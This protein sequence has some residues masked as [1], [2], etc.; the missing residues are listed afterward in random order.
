M[1]RVR[2]CIGAPRPLYARETHVFTIIVTFM[3][4]QHAYGIPN[5]ISTVFYLSITLG[6][7]KERTIHLFVA[8]DGNWIHRYLPNERWAIMHHAQNTILM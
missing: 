6:A 1:L 2:I 4:G 8:D 3:Y 5:N 7:L